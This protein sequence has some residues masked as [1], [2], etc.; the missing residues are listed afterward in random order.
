MKPGRLLVAVLLAV[1]ANTARSQADQRL[2]APYIEGS[3][4][5]SIRD[6]ASDISPIIGKLASTASAEQLTA[7]IRARYVRDGY[8]TPI[9]R[10]PTEDSRSATPHLYI[11]EARIVDVVITGNPGPYRNRI[12]AA[13]RKLGS[14]ALRKESLRQTLLRISELP[15]ITARA[16]FEPQPGMAN[17]FVVVIDT[18]YRAVGGELDANNGGTSQLGNAL[19]AASLFFNDLLGGGEQIQVR[20]ATSS[21]FD[22]YQFEDARIQAA[23]GASE[24]SIEVEHSEA[25]PDPNVHFADR[26]ATIGFDHPMAVATGILSLTMSVHADD[27]EI[28]DARN[29]H[30]TDDQIRSAALGLEFADPQSSSPLSMYST[31]E[32]GA[33]LLGAA[34]LDAADS[35]VQTAFT[36]YLFGVAQSVTFAPEWRMRINIDAQASPD[37]LPIVERFAFGGLGLGEAFDPASLVGDSG[38]AA[39]VEIGRALA[40]HM[41]ALQSA[42]AFVRADYGVAWNNASY[43]PRRDDAASLSLGV[44][45]KW[46]QAILTVELSTPV[47][48]PSYAP[49]ASP[50]RALAS[51]AVTF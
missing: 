21:L 25:V 17:E 18:R 40:I 9:V 35:E 24:L 11:F 41:N 31:V 33:K 51:L 32:H 39:A 46:P 14:G 13:L 36:K 16:I 10:M 30:L 43:L 6:L 48:Q 8:I 7:A 27:N 22:H 2:L 45:G 3:S 44:L 38:G 37:V 26:N 49:R 1:V 23:T 12:A 19:Y 29:I 4:V 50:V 20:A 15:G 34:S 5:Y 28:H 47:R 42:T